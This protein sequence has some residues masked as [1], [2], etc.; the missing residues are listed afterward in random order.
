MLACTVTTTYPALVIALRAD[1]KNPPPAP[2]MPSRSSSL[3]AALRAVFRGPWGARCPAPSRDS[4]LRCGS[5]AF[6]HDPRPDHVSPAAASALHIYATIAFP[7]SS[8]WRKSVLPG[9]T[10]PILCTTLR[11][12]GDGHGPRRRV[13][14]GFDRTRKKK[15]SSAEWRDPHAPDAATK[16]TTPTRRWRTCV[17]NRWDAAFLGALHA[18]FVVDDLSPAR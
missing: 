5:S 7:A 15:T 16:G 8:L 12:H 17:R 2:V 13:P 11:P 4:P 9:S 10:V 1:N 3:A 6:D 18:D 14:T